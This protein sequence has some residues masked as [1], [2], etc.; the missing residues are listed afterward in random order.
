MSATKIGDVM[1]R[2]WKQPQLFQRPLPKHIVVINT[3]DLDLATKEGIQI[4]IK[5]MF[6]VPS[7]KSIL[8]DFLVG[9]KR[10]TP[11][12]S[13]EHAEL[14]RL[15]AL[16]NHRLHSKRFDYLGDSFAAQLFR[17][18]IREKSF[19]PQFKKDAESPIE[20]QVISAAE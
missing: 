15:Q 6:E 14:H 13:E 5:R 20:L 19:I 4:C 10:G 11:H 9:R 3:G 8:L 2:K 1:A 16:L 18:S 7:D 12:P 17:N